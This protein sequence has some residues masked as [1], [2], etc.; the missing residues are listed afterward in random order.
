MAQQVP[1]TQQVLEESK[2]DFRVPAKAIQFRNL[3]FGIEVAIDQCGDDRERLRATA[4]FDNVI[5]NLAQL[6][7]LW[8]RIL[9][10]LVHPARPFGLFPMDHMVILAQ[11]TPPAKVHVR[12]HTRLRERP[13]HSVPWP[14]LL[15]EENRCHGDV[16]ALR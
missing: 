5:A 10:G 2:E 7:S 6:Q 9:S 14:Q 1:T 15:V 12:S 8:N 16:Y 3:L 13:W 4:L 11:A